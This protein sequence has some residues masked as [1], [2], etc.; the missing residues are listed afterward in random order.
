MTKCVI[1]LDVPIHGED[2]KRSYLQE[3]DSLGFSDS[4]SAT[5]MYPRLIGTL[6][7]RVLIFPNPKAAA[8]FAE[9]FSRCDGMAIPGMAIGYHGITENGNACPPFR[10]VHRNPVVPGPDAVAKIMSGWEER[11]EAKRQMFLPE[12]LTMADVTVGRQ[13]EFSH[14][15]MLDEIRYLT[16]NMVDEEIAAVMD[17][18]SRFNHDSVVITDIDTYPESANIH[19]TRTTGD[20]WQQHFSLTICAF[21]LWDEAGIR[22]LNNLARRRRQHY[23]T[24]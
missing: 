16:D 18:L 4:I 6:D 1:H 5:E 3:H 11:I 14:S 7:S 15:E 8:D 12:L 19:Y 2:M 21:N 22:Q 20:G 9:V 24:R 10:I 17:R 23:G 13:G